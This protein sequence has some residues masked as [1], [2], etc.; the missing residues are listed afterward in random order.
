MLR[1]VSKI[2]QV[3][4]TVQLRI[5]VFR[6]GTPKHYYTGTDVSEQITVSIFRVIK[7]S[8]ILPTV[9]QK[10][11]NIQITYPHFPYILY[12]LL[13]AAY[14][15]WTTLKILRNDLIHVPIYMASY[16]ERLKGTYIF[17]HGS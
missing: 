13:N 14:L 3:L 6:D 10:P 15:D 17:S 16:T 7:Q 12:R 1:T 9:T 8:L 5:Q 4:T 2:F 11:R